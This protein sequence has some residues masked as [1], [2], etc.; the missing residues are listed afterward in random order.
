MAGSNIEIKIQVRTTSNPSF[1][2]PGQYTRQHSLGCRPVWS[3]QHPYPRSQF[4]TPRCRVVDGI[5]A[6]VTH[7]VGL[8]PIN[9][10]RRPV[11]QQSQARAYAGF[12]QESRMQ[13]L[14]RLPT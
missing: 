14:H 7:L 1:N 6:A 12:N 5:L 13:G 11:W 10:T 4:E 2:I 3:I 8:W 9:G